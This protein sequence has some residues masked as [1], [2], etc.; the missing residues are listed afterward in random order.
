[1]HDQ[2]PTNNTVGARHDGKPLCNEFEFRH[3]RT[4][5][6]QRYK[7][8]SMVYVPALP[9][10]SHTAWVEKAFGCH[11]VT[12]TVSCLVHVKAVLLTRT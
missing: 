11:A 4:V 9:A 10:V 1:M 2:T 6:A 12:A 8:T 3:A 7:V 5:R